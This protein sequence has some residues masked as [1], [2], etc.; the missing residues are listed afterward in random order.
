V[1]DSFQFSA[2]FDQTKQ[3]LD[4][5]SEG[6]SERALSTLEKAASIAAGDLQNS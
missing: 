3:S 6:M 5:L 1:C 2:A 4:T